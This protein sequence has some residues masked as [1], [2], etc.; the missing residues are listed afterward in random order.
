MFKM[1]NIPRFR[2]DLLIIGLLLVG[3]IVCVWTHYQAYQYKEYRHLPLNAKLQLIDS[4]QI[5]QKDSL[6]N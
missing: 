5:K 3:L 4:V 2:G 6:K 1:E